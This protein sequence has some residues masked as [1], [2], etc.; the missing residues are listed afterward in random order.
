MLNH[1]TLRSPR[2][3]TAGWAAQESAHGARLQRSVLVVLCEETVG[4]IRELTVHIKEYHTFSARQL[5]K[6]A[7][8]K[9]FT[10]TL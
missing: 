10:S 6:V 2:G 9:G 1:A 4:V 8:E 3:H 5:S 7:S